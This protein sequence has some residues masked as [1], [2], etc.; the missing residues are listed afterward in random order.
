MEFPIIPNK[1][2]P[3]IPFITTISCR[4][5]RVFD[6]VSSKRPSAHELQNKIKRKFSSYEDDR[7]P[8]VHLTRAICFVQL[9]SSARM[10]RGLVFGYASP[11]LIRLIE[12]PFLIPSTTLKFRTKFHA[13]AIV[14][15]GAV[16]CLRALL[17]KQLKVSCL[18]APP[19]HRHP[20]Q[21]QFPP[22]FE[23]TGRNSKRVQCLEARLDD[24]T[25]RD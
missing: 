22:G 21:R 12:A 19:R 18:S 5:V 13:A 17:R 9:S 3:F 23:R 15:G 4:R 11:R 6:R 16:R 20:P 10:N 25:V 7:I 2:V 1:P 8:V 24:A 14:R